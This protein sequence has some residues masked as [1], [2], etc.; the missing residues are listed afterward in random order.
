MQPGEQCPMV[1]LCH[2]FGGSKEGQMFDLIADSLCR[3]GIAS[4]RFDFNGHGQSEGEF[5][6]MTVP[7][8][9]ADAHRVYEYVRD[10]RY[11]SRIGIVGHSMG[12]VVSSMLAGQLSEEAGE[13]EASPLSCVVLLA[14]A[15][16][17][18]DDCIRGTI[19]DQ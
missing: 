5:Q 12:G 14:P 18:R 4:I 1:I 13:G 8:E 7:N 9:I 10:L 3:H 16:T 19:F 2:G 6:Q 11:V 17:L 15:A